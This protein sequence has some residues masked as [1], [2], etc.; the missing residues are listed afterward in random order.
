[1]DVARMMPRVAGAC[2]GLLAFTIALVG[3]LVSQNPAT[4]VLSRGILALFLFFFIGF[5]LGAVA[6]RVVAEYERQRKEELNSREAADPQGAAPGESRAD[7][8][9]DRSVPVAT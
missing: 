1:M 3:G 5:A 6:Q 2:L 4:V 8:A 7:S 9:A